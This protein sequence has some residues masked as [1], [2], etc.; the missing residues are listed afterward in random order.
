M[1]ERYLSD[2]SA[3]RRLGELW[4]ERFC[5]FA[6]WY[7]KSWHAYQKDRGTA[8]CWEKTGR[9]QLT[10]DIQIF[11]AG[12]ESHEVKHKNPTQARGSCARRY[13]LEKYRLQHLTAF[14]RE[15]QQAVFYTIHDW[16]AAGARTSD[17]SMPNVL[18]DWRIAHV[19]ELA[20]DCRQRRPDDMWSWCRGEATKV[21]GYYWATS[22]W[23]PLDVYWGLPY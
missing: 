16:E 2:N 3:D 20:A 11:C 22:L 23:V 14:Q 18:Q 7:G 10:P 21:P 6:D 1:S 17:A 8:A 4:E 15:S 12:G 19:I 5:A 9:K 13:G